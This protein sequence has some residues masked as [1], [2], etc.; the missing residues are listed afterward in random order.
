MKRESWEYVEANPIPSV[1]RDCEERASCLARGE[2]E[3][4]CEECEHLG[5]QF[6][7]MR[8]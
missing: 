8:A 4:C 2:G 1:C 3:W 7:R 6:V 5:E